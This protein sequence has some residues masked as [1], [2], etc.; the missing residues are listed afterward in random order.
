M[1]PESP[2]LL[3]FLAYFGRFIA[4]LLGFLDRTAHLY[5]RPGVDS[6]GKNRPRARCSD[7]MKGVHSFFCAGKCQ[8]P[9]RN[10][11]CFLPRRGFR[12]QLHSQHVLQKRRNDYVVG[13]QKARKLPGVGF[14]SD[15]QRRENLIYAIL[16][17]SWR[18]GRLFYGTFA[19]AACISH[20][21]SPCPSTVRGQR[22]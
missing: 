7:S 21:G 17:H 19:S 2:I 14:L 10:S 12:E 13:R 22:R 11:A 3:N 18:F 6:I 16:R 1:R 5:T 20:A 8:F 9:H 4:H 15:M